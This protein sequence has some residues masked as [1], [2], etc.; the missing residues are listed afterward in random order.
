MTQTEFD[1]QTLV[2]TGRK[3][4]TQTAELTFA[5]SDGNRLKISLPV[6]VAADMLVPVLAQFEQENPSQPGGPVFSQNV[7]HWRIGRSNEEPLVL[8]SL[9]DDHFYS[10]TVPNAK[11]VWREIREEAEIVERRSP[12]RRQ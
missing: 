10:L 2:E 5:D 9:N 12:P 4:A 7:S 1:A 8:L 6:R 3:Q 11:K